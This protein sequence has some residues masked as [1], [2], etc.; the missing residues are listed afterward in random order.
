MRKNIT[1]NNTFN[2]VPIA[3]FFG[4]LGWLLLLLINLFIINDLAISRLCTAGVGVGIVGLFIYNW[5][6]SAAK[7]NKKTSQTVLKDSK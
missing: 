6:L 1:K 3:I 7:K 2:N 5:Q 4:F